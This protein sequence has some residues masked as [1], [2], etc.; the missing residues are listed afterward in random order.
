MHIPACGSLRCLGR[1]RFAFSAREASWFHRPIVPRRHIRV[2]AQPPFQHVLPHLIEERVGRVT[3]RPLRLRCQFGGE[4]EQ[5]HGGIEPRRHKE[6]AGEARYAGRRAHH[7]MQGRL[8]IAVGGQLKQLADI[9]HQRSR[10]GGAEIQ[11]SA[12]STSSPE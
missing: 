6:G 10:Q 7:P 1:Y 9:D 3:I 4:A 2:G 11:P 5:W 12:V 8:E